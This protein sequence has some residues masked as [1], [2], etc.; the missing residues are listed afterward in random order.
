MQLLYFIYHLNIRCYHLV[1]RISHRFEINKFPD[2]IIFSWLL[3]IDFFQNSVTVNYVIKVVGYQLKN[4]TIKIICKTINDI[5]NEI[6]DKFL[7]TRWNK[8]R[9]KIVLWIYSHC[10]KHS[11]F[12]KIGHKLGKLK[13]LEGT[14][15]FN[16][17]QVTCKSCRKI[18]SPFP[19]LLGLK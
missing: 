12:V 10:N 15:K 7:D 2:S 9:N 6:L 19:Q 18:F 14:I 5:Q 4:I 1:S 3:N 8:S 16:L 17:Y 11:F 13:I